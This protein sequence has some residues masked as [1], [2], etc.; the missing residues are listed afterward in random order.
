MPS[1][2]G[3][4]SIHTNGVARNPIGISSASYSD[5]VCQIFA[6]LRLPG[7]LANSELIAAAHETLAQRDA[8]LSACHSINFKCPIRNFSNGSSQPCIVTLSGEEI[9]AL[10]AAIALCE[11]TEA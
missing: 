5:E 4:E 11:K 3:S 1:V 8:L 9:L 6:D 7:P 10:R 2:R